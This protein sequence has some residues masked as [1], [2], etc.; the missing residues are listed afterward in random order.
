V[1]EG[2]RGDLEVKHHFFLSPYVLEKWGCFYGKIA[3]NITA[4][5]VRGITVRLKYAKY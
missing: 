3:D 4:S 1:A 2:S 5:G